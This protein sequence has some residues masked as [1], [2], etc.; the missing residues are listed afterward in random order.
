MNSNI[1]AA[2]K[3]KYIDLG[4]PSGNFWCNENIEGLFTWEETNL[5][6]VALPKLTDF[7]EL[8]DYCKWEWN[9]KRKGMD[10]IGPNNKRI[11]LPAEGHKYTNDGQI[12]GKEECGYYWSSSHNKTNPFCLAFYN[13]KD[14]YPYGRNNPNYGFSVRLVKRKLTEK[15]AIQGDIDR[16][17]EIINTLILLGARYLTEDLMS[18][19]N[20]EMYYF[21]SET[22]LIDCLPKYKMKDCKV[23]KINE[24]LNR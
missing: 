4:L 13:Q 20:P 11:F 24:F 21:I 14:I 7:S 22:G 19:N 15:F 3:N 10:V 16:G 18:G 8:Y 1:K 17:K 5:F 23:Y 2:I 12:V 6:K 9:E